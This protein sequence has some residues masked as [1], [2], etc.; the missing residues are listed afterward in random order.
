MSV[1]IPSTN[2]D[3]DY[4]S[5]TITVTL[6]DLNWEAVDIHEIRV[7]FRIPGYYSN[8]AT[9]STINSIG[10]SQ[11]RSTTF[12][13]STSWGT[14]YF[15]MKLTC[16]E[17]IPL[18]FDPELYTEWEDYF[19]ITPYSPPTTTTTPTSPNSN[20]SD[21]DL[22]PIILGSVGGFL[23]LVGIITGVYIIINKRKKTVSQAYL[24]SP[25]EATLYH[26]QFCVNCGLEIKNGDS[27][28]S[29]CGAKRDG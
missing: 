16:R 17:N 28:C 29:N 19:V 1:S 25:S 10:G 18:A 11:Q 13:Y 6:E 9:F 2:L 3:D 27:F 12:Q 24:S 20:G 4:H 26:S 7:D 21:L 22:L 15:Q 14:N 8:Y 23:G 5:I